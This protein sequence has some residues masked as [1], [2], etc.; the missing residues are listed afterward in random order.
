MEQTSI[1]YKTTK[2]FTSPQLKD[3]FLS[4]GW[5][6]G[7]SPD[8]LVKAMSNSET[9]FSAWDGEKLIGLVNALDDG[10]LTAYA[11]Y[12]LVNP[13][14]QGH[15]IGSKLLTALKEK[16]A[17]YMYL[18]LTS[19]SEKTVGFYKK[20]GFSVVEGAVPMAVIRL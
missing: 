2:T 5:L 11:H 17:G 4:V 9:V 16:Y 3:L 20:L 13:L 15:G 18:V 19:E 7:N 1:S 12:L 14:Y 10:E 6:S 8:R